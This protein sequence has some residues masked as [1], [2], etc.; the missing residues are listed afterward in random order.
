[1]SIAE[2]QP[3]HAARL[4]G[5][6]QETR[7]RLDA[8]SIDPRET[9]ELQQALEQLAATLGE[10]TRDRQMAHGARLDLDDAVALALQG[11]S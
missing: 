7:R 1:M 4:L 2:D 10:A 8:P 3:Q 11:P 5:C 9:A 6:A